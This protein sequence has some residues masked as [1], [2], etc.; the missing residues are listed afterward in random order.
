M[1]K[2]LPVLLKT[3]ENV[4]TQVETKRPT[5][6]LIAETEEAVKKNEFLGLRNFVSGCISSITGEDI[7]IT[8]KIQIKTAVGKMSNKSV[9]YLSQEIMIDYYEGDDYVEGVYTCPRCNTQHIFEKSIQDGIDMDNRDKISDLIVTFMEDPSEL[10]FDIEFKNPIVVSSSQLEEEINNVT[11]TFP[12][13]DDHIEVLNTV[14]RNNMTRLQYALYSRAIV[15]ANGLE[16]D[17]SWRRSKGIQLFLNSDNV[18]EDVGKMAEYINRYG[19][20]HRLEKV[21]KNCSKVWQPVI[22]TSNF[23]GSALL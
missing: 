6:V 5:G 14:G 4:Y 7:E 22:N 17:N 8:D 15:K 20:D 21:C 9:E 23:F 13:M 10:L 11:M 12:T 19:V 18:K 16:V 2:R 3:N 1:I